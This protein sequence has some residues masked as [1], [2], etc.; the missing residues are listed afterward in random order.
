MMKKIKIGDVLDVKRGASLSGEYYKTNGKYIRLTLGNFNY[1]SS[2]WKQNTSKDDIYYDGPISPDFIMS[3]GDIITPLTEQV[4]GLLGNTATIPE[5]NRYIQSG[6]VGKIITD[7]SK[8]YNR[9][10]YYLM[11]SNIVKKQLDA[12]SQQTKIRH[13]SPDRI[14]ECIAY[15]P[16][17]ETQIKI[18]RILDQINSKI[19]V[20]N[21]INDNLSYQSAMVA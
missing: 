20:N 14:K 9:F 3:K 4:R 11:S 21:L 10:A 13:T 16:K 17:I 8:I 7:D 1:P 2:G 18:S 5:D 19:E 12:G 6:D 15:I